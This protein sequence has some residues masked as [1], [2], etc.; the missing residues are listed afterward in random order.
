MKTGALKSNSLKF[1]LFIYIQLLAFIPLF[2][3]A[4][5]GSSKKDTLAI[6]VKTN[7]ISEERFIMI[8]GI[9]QWVT[10][11]GE[12]TKPAILFLHGGPGSPISP[13]ADAIYGGWEKDFILIQW[14]QRGTGKT[15]GKNAPAELDA[16]YLKSNPLTVEQMVSDG[17]ALT[18]YLRK[19]LGK[20]KFILL[21]SS[22][23][24]ELGVSMVIKR[25][26]LFCAYVGH[27]QVVDPSENLVYDYQKILKMAQRAGDQQSVNELRMIGAPPYDT[28]RNAGRLFR[29][30]KKYERQ[31]SVPAPDS[32]WKPS[33]LY[34]SKKDEQD[35]ADGDDYSFVNY[36]GDKRLGVIPMMATVHLSKN[37]LDFKVPV[38][39]I[40][41]E[42]D[43]LTPKEISKKYFDQIRAPK[44]EYV[45][46]P[47]AAHGFNASVLKAQ[48][49]IV[50]SISCP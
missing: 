20:E 26:D 18:E 8:N 50:Q 14:D 6:P 4:Q 45:L 33:P 13:Y 11:K 40:Q 28:A 30:I 46:V 16:D 44:K 5:N 38:Y 41:G 34:D 35:R 9:D 49:K 17:I 10:I 23:G 27:S 22:W 25:P 32:I 29:V 47:G 19:Y 37:A 48:F 24:S 36:V 21:G 7:R 1:H 2:T 39:L 3:F 12:R 31:N 15:Y 43:I 42:E